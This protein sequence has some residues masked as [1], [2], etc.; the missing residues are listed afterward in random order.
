MKIRSIELAQKLVDLYLEMFLYYVGATNVAGYAFV[1]DSYP[2]SLDLFQ[3]AHGL[4][5]Q[6]INQ[7]ERM[8]SLRPGEIDIFNDFDQMFYWHDK[9]IEHMEKYKKTI[10]K[11]GSLFT[12]EPTGLLEFREK[13]T[14]L[15]ELCKQHMETGESAFVQSLPEKVT[16]ENLMG[17]LN[18]RL[19][20]LMAEYQIPSEFYKNLM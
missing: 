8:K 14:K 13:Q 5:N 9:W 6:G 7:M 10:S 2:K 15:D 20:T 19:E 11:K 18:K 4:N 1:T 16:L 12:N 3:K 17:M